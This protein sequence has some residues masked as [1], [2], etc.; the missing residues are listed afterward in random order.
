MRKLM[1]SIKRIDEEYTRKDFVMVADILTK[2][3]DVDARQ[4]NA[5][6]YADVFAQS[7]P[8]FDRAKFLQAANAASGERDCPECDGEGNTGTEGGFT[9][10][11]CDNCDG[12]GIIGWTNE[13]LSEDEY[14]D[15]TD[16]P[17]VPDRIYAQIV[18]DLA[19]AKPGYQPGAM[20]KTTDQPNQVS[21]M[22]WNPE[23]DHEEDMIFNTDTMSFEDS[24]DDFMLANPFESVNEGDSDRNDLWCRN[25]SAM[26]E[27]ECVCDD[28][29]ES[30]HSRLAA[31]AEDIAH[32]NKRMPDDELIELIRTQLGD[33][34]AQY[35]S[36]KLAGGETDWKENLRKTLDNM[37]KPNYSWSNRTDGLEEGEED[38]NLGPY[39]ENYEQWLG[40]TVKITG[41]EYQGET[42]KVIDATWEYSDSGSKEGVYQI[43][44]YSGPV[45]TLYLSEWSH[46]Q[47]ELAYDPTHRP[48]GK[49]NPE[50]EEDEEELEKLDAD[51]TC[52]SCRGSG[53][54][55]PYSGIIRLPCKCG[56]AGRKKREQGLEEDYRSATTWRGPI[57]TPDKPKTKAQQKKYDAR[58]A[59]RDAG[60]KKAYRTTDVEEGTFRHEEDPI[61]VQVKSLLAQGKKVMSKIGGAMGEVT[62]TD[63]RLLYIKYPGRRE[64]VTSFDSKAGVSIRGELDHYDIIASSNDLNEAVGRVVEVPPE[65]RGSSAMTGGATSEDA[66]RFLADL[67]PDDDV[68]HDVVD[69][70][71]GELLDWPT[72]GLDHQ[73]DD[74]W[75]LR[76]GGTK[77]ERGQAKYK[78]DQTNKVEYDNVPILYIDDSEDEYGYEFGGG[79]AQLLSD[80]R[81]SDF[82]NVVWRDQ[83]DDVEDPDMM[84]DNDYDIDVE[85]PVALK[86][87]DGKKLTSD[88]HDNI[89]VIM[90]AVK[91]AS[92]L[93]NIGI[94]YAGTSNEGTTA[95]F[96]AM[97]M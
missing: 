32:Y 44:L 19:K 36:D 52:R 77:R 64:G 72:A 31:A 16:G 66:E 39:E 76:G 24:E 4:A 48:D 42:G 81:N 53:W 83:A 35:M 45:V 18:A 56:D 1:E 78:R 51:P 60:M 96:H 92:T 65:L 68:S 3:E 90:K 33:M 8:R 84:R 14:D 23:T 88:D 69:P 26:S 49:Y 86:R 11:F 62:R 85:V 74:D 94:G 71:T 95:R 58:K 91:Q 97:F 6:L 55:N 82:Y 75:R 30:Y 17:L 10:E 20:G 46:D 41:G 47:I 29:N 54:V 57:Q 93:G 40:Q 89:E 5:N 21:V 25:C 37:D 79:A 61:S 13:G 43:K 27:D 59:K 73:Q 70:E 15:D 22:A 38:K 63:G 34:A 80:L 67:G 7:N 12:E 2:I 9:G 87:K 28:I 50:L